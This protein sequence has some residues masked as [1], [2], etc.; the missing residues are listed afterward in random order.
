[1]SRVDDISIN[2]LVETSEHIS[3][4]VN[5][6]G[7]EALKQIIETFGGDV[8][9]IPMPESVIKPARDHNIYQQF[10]GRNYRELADRYRLS[11]RQIRNIIQQQRE[12]NCKGGKQEEM[13]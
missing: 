3:Q 4:L 1:M 5:I 12:T 2:T 13:F 7:R 10:N 6:V 11:I 9:Y 8:I